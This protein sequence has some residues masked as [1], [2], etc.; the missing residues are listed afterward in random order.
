MNKILYIF[1]SLL[2][3]GCFNSNKENK[4]TLT[5]ELNIAKDSAMY[6]TKPS[7]LTNKY[8]GFNSPKAINHI[9]KIENEYFNDY[10]KSESKYYGTAW[11]QTV[12]LDSINN[13]NNNMSSVFDSY[14]L[15]ITSKNEQVDSM[16][17]TIYAVEALKAGL[18]K[19]YKFL[20]NYHKKIWKNREYAGWSVA[21]ILTKYFNW[22]AYLITSKE[23]KEYNSAIT[24]FKKDQKY[25]VWKQPNIPIEKVYNFEQNKEQIDSLLNLNEFGWGFSDQ[26][27]HTWITRF[28]TLK[29]CNWAGSPSKKYTNTD[30][31]L[32][33][34]TNFTEY[35]DYSTHI[36]A[37]PPKK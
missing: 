16:H 32:F 18:E 2:M 17:C 4:N 14:K 35:Y 1:V 22:K 33:I 21:Y 36:V 6:F 20:E 28:N 3:L 9:A 8:L 10:E 12:K 29:E 19:D 30:P 37:F 31:D 7:R 34:S 25:H 27:W 13:N 5:V 24:N 11:Y 26:G 23:S 15:K